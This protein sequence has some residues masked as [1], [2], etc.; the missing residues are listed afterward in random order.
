MKNFTNNE[1]LCHNEYMTKAFKFYG[2]SKFYGI[3]KKINFLIYRKKSTEL[4][5]IEYISAFLA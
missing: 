3:L 5:S 2:M 4:F 1:N